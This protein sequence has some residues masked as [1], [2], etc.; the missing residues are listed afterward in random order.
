MIRGPPIST[1]TDTLIPYTTLFRSVVVRRHVDARAG[2]RPGA[3]RHALVA[4]EQA[5]A[6]VVD[7]ADES[8]PAAGG[9]VLV[10]SQ[11]LRQPRAGAVVA[12]FVPQRAADG[13]G[14]PALGRGAAAPVARSEEVRLGGEG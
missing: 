5:G 8:Q 11:D 2:Q 6:V 10:A 14:L 13:V 12:V 1:R 7:V 9:N 3:R 4:G